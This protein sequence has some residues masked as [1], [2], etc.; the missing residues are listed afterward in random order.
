MPPTSPSPLPLHG[1]WR[2][3]TTAD[4]LA[5]LKVD[6]IAEDH[7]GYLWFATMGGVSRFDGEAFRTFTPHDGLSANIVLSVLCDRQGRIWCG[8]YSGVCWYDG[9]TWHRLTAGGSPLD[10]HI[11]FMY[12]DDQGRVWLAGN[13]GS[14]LVAGYIEGTTYCDLSA[15]LKKEYNGPMGSSC[16]GIIQDRQGRIWLGFHDLVLRYEDGRFVHFGP[17]DGLVRTSHKGP[18]LALTVDGEGGLFL[19]FPGPPESLRPFLPHLGDGLFESL[20]GTRGLGGRRLEILFRRFLDAFQRIGPF[21][22]RL[23]DP[24]LQSRQT[25]PGSPGKLRRLFK[26][27]DKGRLQFIERLDPGLLQFVKAFLDPLGPLPSPG[28]V[29]NRGVGC[30]RF[31]LIDRPDPVQNPRPDSGRQQDYEQYIRERGDDFTDS[32]NN[33]VRSS[34]EISGDKT[35]RHPEQERSG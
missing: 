16:W 11:S 29:L 28:G 20:A 3:Y 5:S 22:L 7:D 23:L 1:T 9:H 26:F 15:A 19:G 24:P 10:Y 32:G 25:L 14:I 8:T 34:P 12:E 27:F 4:G 13:N 18:S 33:G 6:H 30:G 21:R 17:D 2:T 31:K 35:Q